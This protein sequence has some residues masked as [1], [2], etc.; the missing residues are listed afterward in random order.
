MFF[1]QRRSKP[2]YLYW[3]AALPLWMV[4]L[5]MAV[6]TA[7]LWWRDRR[8]PPGRCQFCGYDLTAN[9]SGVCPECGS[10]INES[11]SGERADADMLV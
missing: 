7:F 10:A 5:T 11:D 6:P 8:W 4:A 3:R 1:T 2:E 9:T